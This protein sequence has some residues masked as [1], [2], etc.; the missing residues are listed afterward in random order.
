MNS[1]IYQH[2]RLNQEVQF[3]KDY[4]SPDFNITI[5]EIEE[6]IT[7]SVIKTDPNGDENDWWG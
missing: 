3:M 6:V 7:I 1:I 4:S 5:F 2:F